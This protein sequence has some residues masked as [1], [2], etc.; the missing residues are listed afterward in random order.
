M[1]N[2]QLPAGIGLVSGTLSKK[3]IVTSQGTITRRVVACVRNG[4]QKIYFREDQPRRTKLSDRE[5]T[6]RSSFVIMAAEVTR[7]M[8][9][10]D[11]RPRKLIWAD[12]KA[13]FKKGGTPCK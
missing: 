13:D 6:A 8:E 9:A 11:K 3:S 7:R 5:M 4:K 12:V 2:L 1:A 10:G